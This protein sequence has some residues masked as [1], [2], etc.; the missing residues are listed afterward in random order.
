MQRIILF[1]GTPTTLKRQKQYAHLALGYTDNFVQADYLPLN[2]AQA[3][4]SMVSNALD[5]VLWNK[6]LYHGNV[7]PQYLQDIMTHTISLA[8]PKPY[9]DYAYGLMRMQTKTSSY[10]YAHTGGIPGYTTLLVYYP[11]MDLH[12]VVFTN[13]APEKNNSA[14]NMNKILFTMVK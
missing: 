1:S 12:V 8:K 6:A 2:M 10:V 4:G 3:A 9:L 13:F 14:I 11:S 5:L 7:L